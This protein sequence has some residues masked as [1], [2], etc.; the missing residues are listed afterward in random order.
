MPKPNTHP[1]LSPK[2][3]ALKLYEEE[4]KNVLS[5]KKDVEDINIKIEK[6]E[7]KIK[8]LKSDRRDVI[9]G[10]N[11]H[12]YRQE[13]HLLF[14]RNRYKFLKEDMLETVYNRRMFKKHTKIET[15]TIPMEEEVYRAYLSALSSI[16]EREEESSREG[17]K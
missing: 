1:N 15:K 5:V 3:R 14:E 9:Q 6:L 7:N 8:K 17:G 11:V 16:K 13:K 2:G 12:V 10:V 4:K